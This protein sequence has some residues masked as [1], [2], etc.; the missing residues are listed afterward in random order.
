MMSLSDLLLL[1]RDFV[2]FVNVD[3][4]WLGTKVK[5]EQLDE[6]CNCVAQ[7]LR[8][9]RGMQSDETLRTRVGY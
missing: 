6:P 3:E 5:L 7:V 9:V 2:T 8:I 4:V 1:D